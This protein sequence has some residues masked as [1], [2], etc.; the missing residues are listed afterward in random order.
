MLG[1]RRHG[2][3]HRLR[4]YVALVPEL[5]RRPRGRRIA[6]G[7]V[8]LRRGTAA[9]RCE[10]ERARVDASPAKAPRW[11]RSAL[12]VIARA[13]PLE[14]RLARREGDEAIRRRVKGDDRR[15]LGQ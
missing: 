4:T 13:K 5:A 11:P 8:P 6:R 9:G 3:E 10:A 2:A 15:V 7:E 1:I 14:G 12:T